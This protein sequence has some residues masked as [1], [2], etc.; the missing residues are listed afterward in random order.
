MAHTLH[1]GAIESKAEKNKQSH[2]LISTVEISISLTGNA[3]PFVSFHFDGCGGEKRCV[4]HVAL[5][6]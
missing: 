5:L 3:S 1:N 4:N 6:E 2:G